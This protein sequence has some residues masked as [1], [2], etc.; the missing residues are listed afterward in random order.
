MARRHADFPVHPTFVVRP[1]MLLFVYDP[2]ALMSLTRVLP[3]GR[4]G[5]APCASANHR[6]MPA[7]DVMSQHSPGCT[8]DRAAYRGVAALI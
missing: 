6:A 3:D 2:T 1:A 5:R 4:A 8:A 7:A